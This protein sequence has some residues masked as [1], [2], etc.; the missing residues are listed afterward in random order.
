ML[1]TKETVKKTKDEALSL[2]ESI[3]GDEVLKDM[4]RAEL[5]LLCKGLPREVRIKISSKRYYLKNQAGYRRFIKIKKDYDGNVPDDVR[6]LYIKR[7]NLKLKRS[8][9]NLKKL[10]LDMFNN[11]PLVSDEVKLLYNRLILLL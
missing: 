5:E 8:Q 6:D 2:I 1:S 3:G 10:T 7:G 11:D 4:E 9:D